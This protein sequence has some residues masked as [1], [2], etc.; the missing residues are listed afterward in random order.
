[1]VQGKMCKG[2]HGK[3]SA[4]ISLQVSEMIFGGS[5]IGKLLINADAI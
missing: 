3:I 4:G 2:A 1:M 5:A